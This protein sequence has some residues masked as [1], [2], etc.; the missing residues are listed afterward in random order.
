[1]AD[2]SVPA[3]Q[4]NTGIY[5]IV[6]TGNGRRYVGSA[7]NFIR[8]FNVHRSQLRHNKHHNVR[9]QRDWD[10]L[11]PSAF[12]FRQ[13]LVCEK[14]DL[15]LYEQI[16]IDA[17]QPE[18]NLAPIAGSNLGVKYSAAT[19]EKA[20]KRMLNNSLARGVKRSDADKAH[21]VGNKFGVGKTHT[22]E[23]RKYMARVNAGNSYARGA[24]HSPEIK[25]LRSAT[26]KRRWAELKAGGHTGGFGSLPPESK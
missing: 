5:E 23:W 17:T 11:G 20:S 4:F 3:R 26:M 13:L 15:I 2:Q 9:I 7:V 24:K 16:L 10:K 8:R 1:M 6:N 22:D 12:E 18:Y 25:A 21:L 19:C 14:K